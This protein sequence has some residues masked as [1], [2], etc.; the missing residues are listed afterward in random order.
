MRRTILGL[1]R[2]ALLVF[3]PAHLFSKW[4]NLA[5]W[6]NAMAI[7]DATQTW[8]EHFDP[9]F[10]L[11]YYADVRNAR[12][13]PFFHFLLRGN[14]ERRNP[15]PKFDTADYLNRYPDVAASGL[16]PLLHFAVFGKRE[17]RM[18]KAFGGAPT[19]ATPR[20][21]NNEWS[22]DAPLVSVIVPCFNYGGHVEG[23]IRSVLDQTFQNLEI[24]VVEGGSTDAESV[25][26]VRRLEAAAPA[27]TRFFFRSERHL[28]GDNRNF[29]IGQARGR[30]VC[31][32]DADDRL[33]PIYLE[34]AVFLAEAVGYD[35]VYPSVQVLDSDD[36][37]WPACAASF[38]GIPDRNLVPTVALFRRAAWAHVGGFRDW[39]TGQDYVFEDW[40]FWIRL[41]GHG[42][43][44]EY[45]P[46][47][48]MLYRMHDQG[49]ST[50][51][52]S[53]DHRDVLR[54]AN[55]GLLQSAESAAGTRTRVL[56]R[57]ANLGPLDTVVRTFAVAAR[58][59]EITITAPEMT[60]RIYN[61]AS[62]FHDRNH[63]K[64]FVRYLARRYRVNLPEV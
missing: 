54:E 14:R 60:P 19:V 4:K 56:N 33:R 6:M 18:A 63:A 49:L 61:L 40:D 21:V 47:A 15:S 51:R 41:L 46:E 64:E 45:I 34:V 13:D 38:P 3:S 23:A 32:L 29:G 26:A 9:P 28:A 2:T 43:Q 39:G 53:Y 1:I 5:L 17:G 31:C 22:V 44:A 55:A 8:R 11:N 20:V 62:L 50:L 48:L 52:P 30:Y 25:E 58:G 59:D 16:N 12:I 24:I 36:I 37:P 10:Y 27:K 7:P 57:F 35:L 42:Y